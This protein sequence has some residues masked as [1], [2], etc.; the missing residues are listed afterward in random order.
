MASIVKNP[1]L[2]IFEIWKTQMEE[3]FP[4]IQVSYDPSATMAKNKKQY[5]RLLM[6]GN[7]GT[8]WDLEG[9]ECA[10]TPSIQSE[11]FAKDPEGTTKAYEIDECSHRIL[12]GMGFRRNYGPEIIS[13]IDSK[14]KRVISRYSRLYTGQLLGEQHYG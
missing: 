6:M 12:T 11:S 9:D 3:E 13:N 10:T 5:A 2:E 8:V 14:I 1:I 7:P 4:E